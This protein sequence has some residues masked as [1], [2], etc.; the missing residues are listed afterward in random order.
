MTAALTCPRRGESPIGDAGGEDRWRPARRPG[1]FATCSYCG[2]VSE[3]GFF[4][5]V[6]ARAVVGPTDKSYKVYLR[7]P[8][9]H[10]DHERIVSA[11]TFEPDDEERSAW[12]PVDDAV[13]E[14]LER[15]GWR[16]EGYLYARYTTD[17]ELQSKF[18]FQHLSEAGRERFV[19]MNNRGALRIGY[20][21]HFYV[22]PF[23]ARRPGAGASPPA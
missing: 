12:L 4:A 18:Y 21:G 20:P 11:I 8:N 16:G 1:G 3:D 9:P 23:F 15:D 19:E 14:H 10:P 22:P 17:P 7:Y 2:S 6:E 13:R 5:L